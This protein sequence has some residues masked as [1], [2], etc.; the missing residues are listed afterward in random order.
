MHISAYQND[1][2][3]LITRL[4]FFFIRPACLRKASASMTFVMLHNM[5]WSAL[6][7][8]KCE[9]QVNAHAHIQPRTILLLFLFYQYFH[10][11]NFHWGT[12]TI[13]LFCGY[14]YITIHR[15][16]GNII[17][18]YNT[19]ILDGC[20]KGCTSPIHNKAILRLYKRKRN[21][22]E[23]DTRLDRL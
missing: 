4:L 17:V 12:T 13:C 2:N 15:N 8:P 18:D 1:V 19:R 7:N 5:H 20:G 3:V 22:R 6:G 21:P 10:S 9:T 23:K 14:Q 16:A 11:Y